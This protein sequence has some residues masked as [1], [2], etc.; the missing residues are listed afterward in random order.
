MAPSRLKRWLSRLA[1]IYPGEGAVVI[2]CLAVNF[3]VMAGI[4]FGRNARDSLFLVYFGAQY[5]PYM[6]FANAVFLVLTSLVYTTLVDRI[7][8]GKFLAGSSAFFIVSLLVSWVFL[9]THLR[10]GSWFFPVLYIEAQALWYFSLMQFW[11]FV[12]DLFDTR[13]AKRL[14]PLLAVGA[15]LG[16]IG[17]GVGSKSVILALGTANLLAVWAGLILVATVLGGIAFRRYR[18]VNEPPKLD[19]VVARAK[20]NVSEWQK[21]KSG[22]NEVGREPLLRSMAGYTLMLWTLFSVVDFCFKKTMKD[23][24][25]D[26]NDLTRFFGNFTGAQGALCLL[27]QV[28]LTRAVIGRLGVGTTIN[29]HP[30]FLVAGTAWMSLRYGY[31]SVL[32]AKLGD[33]SMLYTFSDSSYQL[34]Y[35]PIPPE[36]RAQI[37]GFIEGYIRPLSLA[38]AGALILVGNNYLKSL[39][40]WGHQIGTAQQL[41]W[42]AFLLAAVWLGFALTAKKGYIRALLRNL[43]G[44]HL[45]LRQAAAMALGKLQD[46]ASLSLLSQTLQSEDPGRVVTAVEFLGSFSYADA[47]G[48]I[49]ALLSHP[50]PRVRATAASALGKLAPAKYVDAL[51]PL[52]ADSDPRVRA[53]AVEALAAARDPSLA[54]RL[55]TLLRDPATRV[56][57][58]T[59]LCLASLEKGP[60]PAECLPLIQELAHGD[61][62][63]RATATYALGRLPMDESV[64]LLTE[65]LRDPEMSIRCEA[66]KALGRVGSTRAIGA[67]VEAL[68]GQSELRH[69]A[70]RSLAAILEKRGSVYIQELSQT[71]L[72]SSRPEIRSE[73]AD[74]LGRIKDPQVNAP[75]IAL[76]KDPEWRVRWKVLKSFDHRARVGPLPENARAA[77]FQYASDELTAFRQSLLWSHALVPKPASESEQLLTQALAED[78]VKIEERVFHMLGIL[79]GRDRMLAIFDKLNSGDARQRADA[80]EALDTL[81][82]KTIGRQVLGLLEPAPLPASGPSPSDGPALEGLVRHSKP[83]VRAC[84]AYYLG[85]HPNGNAVSLLQT[86]LVDREGVVRETAL[87]AGWRARREAWRPQM[88]AAA[89]SS[90]PALKRV[91]QSILGGASP[92]P[93]EGSAPMFLTVE[94]VLLLKSAPLFAGLDGEELAALA[95]IAL[96][97]EFEAGET[98]FEQNTPAHHLYL[99]VRGKVEV[100]HRAD[101]TEYP[102]ATLSEKECF[103]EMAIL[104]DQ[105]RSASIKTLEPSTVLKIDRDSFRELIYE[106]PQIAFSIFKI[107]SGRLR[108]KNL[109]AEHVA[110]LDSSR[111]YA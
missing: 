100:I 46:P 18:I 66:A 3:L 45:A 49:A 50:D 11:T 70:R 106:R 8:R 34:L 24:Y 68:A 40:L 98:I 37:R 104:D 23:I 101:S 17:V 103:G 58:N 83:W 6:Y 67:L 88:E 28:F 22:L 111:H 20:T 43:Q 36:R 72:S 82:P 7:E 48:T 30:A 99:L 93:T 16:M 41:S 60:V 26:A 42:G 85:Q 102:I 105:P 31:A 59:M 74:V 57:V 89:Q 76:L 25:P 96:E 53:N 13:Q 78:R 92:N 61:S 33:A 109:E 91:A 35:N 44:D 52:L 32:T 47:S 27:V 9:R 21:I 1:P 51:L 97:K 54:E 4:M 87:Y 79:C 14:Y 12:G 10:Q 107:L 64:D 110:S 90:D 38:A 86:L 71:A 55:R 65:L 29:F 62:T 2:L 77:L 5:L 84:V 108:Q 94:K 19:E 73:L 39:S 56:R 15:L 75:L 63:A 81:A 95:S 80:L 69:A